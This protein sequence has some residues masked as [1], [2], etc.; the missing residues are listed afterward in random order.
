[1][2]EYQLLQEKRKAP[3]KTYVKHRR[4][5]P[6]IPL[7]VIEMDIKIQWVLAHRRYAFILTAIDCIARKTLHW[8]VA[9]AITKEHVVAAWESIIVNYLQPSSLIDKD[10]T[11]EIRNDNDSRF[12]AKI[13]KEYL[14]DN[15]LNQVF[16]HS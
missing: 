7:Q 5:K 6:S 13:A 14:L 4:V 10:I 1:M 15:G 3:G 12:A 9:Y 8:Q 16:T 11:I 2:G